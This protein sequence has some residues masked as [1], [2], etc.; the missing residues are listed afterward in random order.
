VWTK[1]YALFDL[2]LTAITGMFHQPNV[3]ADALAAQGTA[4]FRRWFSALGCQLSAVSRQPRT[5]LAEKRK[6]PCNV[7]SDLLTRR[8]S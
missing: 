7:L 6:K 3:T 5:F 2:G 1:R 8:L 4:A